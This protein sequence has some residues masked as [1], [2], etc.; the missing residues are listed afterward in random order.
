MT[1]DEL[2]TQLMK[3][4]ELY[5]DAGSFDILFEPY[6]DDH[7]FKYSITKVKKEYNNEIRLI[8]E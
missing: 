1:L 2:L 6:H 5:P 7:K 8:E 3:V 4:K